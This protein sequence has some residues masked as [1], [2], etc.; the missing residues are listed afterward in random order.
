MSAELTGGGWYLGGV[1][2]DD[3]RVSLTRYVSATESEVWL[4]DLAGP[5]IRTGPIAAGPSVLR[6][7]PQR[8]A[9]GRVVSPALVGLRAAE[10][11]GARQREQEST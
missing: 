3:R 7:K 1:S 4:M 8:D 9:Y 2:Q 11:S 10:G 6:I 5:K